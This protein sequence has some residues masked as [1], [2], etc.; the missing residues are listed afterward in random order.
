MRILF[1]IVIG[2]VCCFVLKWRE[3]SRRGLI[4]SLYDNGEYLD[5]RELNNDYS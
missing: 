2:L 5:Q 3:Q 4:V 1:V